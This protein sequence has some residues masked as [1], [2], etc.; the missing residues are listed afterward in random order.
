MDRIETYA[1]TNSNQRS[2]CSLVEGKGTLFLEN[3]SCA[4]QGTLVLAGGLQANLD[5]VCGV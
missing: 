3:L 4:I 2:Q 1:G 5:D